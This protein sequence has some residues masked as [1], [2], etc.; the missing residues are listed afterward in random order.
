MPN[1]SVSE[2]NLNPRVRDLRICDRRSL[3]ADR[4]LGA[5]PRRWKTMGVPDRWPNYSKVRFR[6]DQHRA[7][8]AP[9]GSV[10]YIVEVYDD[11]YEVEV[12][13][14]GTGETLFLGAVP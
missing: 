2:R 12:T 13:E 4:P 14:P 11:A 3:R 1:E 10:G 8:G 6:S 7:N 9:E 5:G